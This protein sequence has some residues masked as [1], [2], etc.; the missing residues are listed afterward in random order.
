MN[1]EVRIRRIKTINGKVYG[2]DELKKIYVLNGDKWEKVKGEFEWEY[3]FEFFNEYFYFIK[4][5]KIYRWSGREEEIISDLFFPSRLKF[6]GNLLYVMD[7]EM[8]SVIIFD[9]DFLMKE[10]I[11]SGSPSIFE[12]NE[13]VYLD[14]PYD[15]DVFNDY[16]GVID[17]GNRRTVIYNKENGEYII[18]RVIGEKIRFYNNKEIIILYDSNLYMLNLDT[19]HILHI[20]K[21]YNVID[22]EIANSEIILLS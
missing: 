9:K 21:K 4:N 15:F 14:M 10:T 17:L 8:G 2:F 22:F 16:I 19:G 12:G 20:N 6:R 13:G 11:F 1:M 7:K 3:D 5:R 18:Y